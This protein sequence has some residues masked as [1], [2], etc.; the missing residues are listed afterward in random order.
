MT[1][2][3]SVFLVPWFN[4]NSSVPSVSGLNIRLQVVTCCRKC[5]EK[6]LEVMIGTT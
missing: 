5:C 3:S 2:P 1:Y 6:Q 4:S